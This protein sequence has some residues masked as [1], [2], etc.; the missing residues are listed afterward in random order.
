MFTCDESIRG[1]HKPVRVGDILDSLVDAIGALPE[2]KDSRSEP[3]LEPHFKLA[4]VVHKLVQRAVLKVNFRFQ[5]W[6]RFADSVKPEEASLRLLETP[7]A[8]NVQPP[9][10]ASTWKSFILALLKNLQNADKANWHHRIVARVCIS[11][12]C[13]R[14]Y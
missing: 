11:F 3:I 9:N 14:F 6:V 12:H 8:R 1:N 7:W 5:F 4:S 10:E 2:K 13:N